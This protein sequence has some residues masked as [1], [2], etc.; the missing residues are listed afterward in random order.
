MKLMKRIVAVILM[1]TMLAGMMVG[2]SNKTV[3]K[4]NDE[5]YL[6]RAEW[7]S[8]LAEAMN[9]NTYDNATP[10]YK[11][12]DSS[13]E[14]FDAV[15][16]CR[17]WNVL[18]E[19]EEFK[20]DDIATY[21]FMA[22]TAV[23]ASEG[24]YSSGSDA[25]DE[26]GQIIDY[27]RSTGI[28]S[29]GITDKDLRNGITYDDA[30]MALRTAAM[31][32]TVLSD[33][34]K[35]KEPECNV[36]TEDNVKD[37]RENSSLFIS[38]Q[39]GEYVIASDSIDMFKEGNI[40]IAPADK[41][42]PSGLAQ[43]VSTVRD[44]GDGTATVESST[45]EFEEVFKEFELQGCIPLELSGAELNDGFSIAMDDSDIFYTSYDKNNNSNTASFIDTATSNNNEYMAKDKLE[46]SYTIKIDYSDDAG[47]KSFNFTADDTYASDVFSKITSSTKF[48]HKLQSNTVDA[49]PSEKI[50][51]DDK[52]LEENIEKYSKGEITDDEL[53]NSWDDYTDDVIKD[54]NKKKEIFVISGEL[55]L[56]DIYIKPEINFNKKGVVFSGIKDFSVDMGEKVKLSVK[57]QGKIEKDIPIFIGK[58]YYV[59]PAA[60]VISVGIDL[61]LNVGVD[62]QI[63][64][65][66]EIDN[67][68][69][70]NYENKK[71]KSSSTS[72]TTKEA[73]A[74]VDFY[75]G[76]KIK[77]TLKGFGLSV[78]DVSAVIK[79]DGEGSASL[80]RETS[81]TENSD[82]YIITRKWTI[83][84]KL[85]LYIPL[86][87]LE[88]GTDDKSLL[89]KAKIK[90]KAD[91]IRKTSALCIKLDFVDY[92]YDFDKS[93]TSI[94]KYINDET[95]GKAN[96]A[97]NKNANETNENNLNAVALD[98]S[99]YYIELK[100][101]ANK[102][103][104]IESIPAGYNISDVKWTTSNMSIATVDNG[105]IKA[106]GIGTCTIK[107]VTNDEKYSCEC[108]VSVVE[109]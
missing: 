15:Q 41:E 29:S 24:E 67:S 45:P 102:I 79:V 108:A 98:I 25:D 77:V 71:W 12:V 7:I 94:P 22:T 50:K 46:H 72:K 80:T 91:V 51:E 27:A 68:V 63:T 76:P 89:S 95:T 34:E 5:T 32:Y 65:S 38:A 4:D 58:I 47:K 17:E 33:E 48:S 83:K 35:N 11:D 21:G 2:C 57:T 14:I 1:F 13:N 66:Y 64:L 85:V 49:D 19:S 10:Y 69:K 42:N 20:P 8:L 90:Y 53:L 88:I 54:N 103:V 60:P 78:A 101:D 93:E 73:K 16:A 86:V 39:E 55:T 100:P 31:I 97:K 43:K 61:Y 99:D 105:N 96:P 92:E 9:M 30:V 36:Q 28:L 84:P 107:V 3:K 75:I 109:Q 6:T 87:T 104:T 26:S 106:T 70:V 74:S 18:S 62:G 23:L 52:K 82:N 44:N 81:V 59:V 40:F 37:Y 56:S